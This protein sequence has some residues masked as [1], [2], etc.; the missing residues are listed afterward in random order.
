[1]SEL[2]RLAKEALR[3]QQALDPVAPLQPGALVT[4]Y[5]GGSK[6]EG[7]VD[8]SHTD[9]GGKQWVFVTWGKTWAAVDRRL[10]TV[11]T[12]GRSRDRG[13]STTEDQ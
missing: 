9:P 7:F 6:Q 11:V 8:F 1:M 3:Q 10:L 5:R 13:P 4:W 2:V 12:H